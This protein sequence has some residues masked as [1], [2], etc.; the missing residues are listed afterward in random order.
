MKNFILLLLLFGLVNSTLSQNKETIILSE[1]DSLTLNSINSQGLKLFRKSDCFNKHEE[2]FAIPEF[3]VSSKMPLEDLKFDDYNLLL[4]NLQ[5]IRESKKKLLNEIS[6]SIFLKRNTYVQSSSDFKKFHCYNLDSRFLDF[7]KN[8]IVKV[9]EIKY[10]FYLYNVDTN[11]TFL[12]T[13]SNQLFVHLNKTS[14]IL[15]LNEF[16]QLYKNG[17]V[18]RFS[19]N[20]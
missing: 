13:N 10:L 11:I 14:Q 17:K 3:L 19:N 16:Y 15:S 7:K 4:S 5:V 8:G 12:V 1:L 18:L 2:Y 20:F 9:N 6:W